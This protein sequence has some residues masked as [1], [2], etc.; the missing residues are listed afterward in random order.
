MLLN[1]KNPLVSICIPTYN[2][3]RFLRESLDS[4]V[5]QTYPNKEIIISD[6]VSNDETEKIV[7]EYV[8]KYKVKYYRNEKNIGAEANFTRCI[9]LANGEFIAIFHS[10]DLYLPDMVKKQ[11]EAFQKKPTIGAVFTMASLINSKNEVIGKIKLP[12]KLKGKY[13]YDFPEIFFS[14]LENLNFLVCPSAMVRSKIYKEL[15]PFN[16]KRFKTSADLDMWLRILQI[17]SIAILNEYLIEHRVSNTQGSFQLRYL[18]TEQADFFK[19]MDCYLSVKIG[20]MNI[21]KNVL[22]KY[23]FLRSIDKIR[24][25]INYLIQGKEKDAKSLLKK[26]FSFYVFFGAIRS[27]KKTK[28]LIYWI[29]GLILLVLI[30]LGLWKYIMKSLYYLLYRWKRNLY[31]W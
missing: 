31:N 12:S 2:S 14:V 19:V 1:Q 26:S 28:F 24:C 13:V 11:V 16:E 8:E 29:S 6:N 4:I 5:N 23:E 10:D 3:A 9:E 21:P 30:C 22:N 17:C 25:A 18:R 20:N 7:K 27:F 15:V